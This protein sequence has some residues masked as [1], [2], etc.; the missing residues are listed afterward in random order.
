MST[1][2]ARAPAPPLVTA[3]LILGGPAVL[4]ACV[5]MRAGLS[6]LLGY[7]LSLPAL[8]L[9]VGAV[10]LPALY[11]LAAFVG[12]APS[13]KRVLR[14]ASETLADLGRLLLGF[15]PALGFLTLSSQDPANAPVLGLLALGAATLLGLRA[16]YLRLF[17]AKRRGLLSL[18]LYLAWSSVCLG[19][20]WHLSTLAL[21]V[22]P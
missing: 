16:L 10:M 19:I 3:A 9:G 2:A 12:V 21:E 1:T 8:V 17:A 4:G 20:G 13:A 14:V 6:S 22:Q 18:A 15:V 5:G 7:T 11:I